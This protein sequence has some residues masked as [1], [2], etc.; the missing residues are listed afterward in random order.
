MSVVLG[1]GIL[2]PFLV[3]V[4][5]VK[6]Q[7]DDFIVGPSSIEV[8][9]N[10]YVSSFLDQATDGIGTFAKTRRMSF[11]YRPNSEFVIKTEPVDDSNLVMTCKICDDRSP[12]IGSK[13]LKIHIEEYHKMACHFYE[14]MY[15]DF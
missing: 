14:E 9:N 4:R 5:F 2:S 1:H 3:F 6:D 12:Y 10:D 8:A 7:I 15:P 11:T 13:E